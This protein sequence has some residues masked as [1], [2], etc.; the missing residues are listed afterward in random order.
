MITPLQAVILGIIE[1]IT[2][3]LP[4]SSTGHL[5]LAGEWLGI[6]GESAKAFEVIIQAGALLAVLGLYRNRIW[7]MWRGVIAK[8]AAGR[9]LLV[10]LLISF[11]PAAAAGLLFHGWIKEHL[12]HRGAVTGALA[13]GGILMI[14]VA[15]FFPPHPF[16]FAQGR[17]ALSPKK[18]GTGSLFSMTSS[19][20]FLIGLAQVLSLWPGTSRA[21]VTL[22]A[23]ILL[24][25]PVAAAAEYSFLLALPTLGAA[26]LFDFV[27]NYSVLFQQIAPLSFGIGLVTSAVVA[28][29]AIC[30]F[31]HYLTR[32]S[33]ALFGWYRIILAVLVWSFVR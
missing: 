25:F 22:V 6:Q 3:F 9:R 14:V 21:M 18:N 33:L 23:A 31:V 2:E 28:A 15:R 7:E 5:I 24:G 11:L 12:F 30:S 16:D 13:I 1:G 10:N 19:Q 8:N 27:K 17:P 26:A 4:I 32:H 20:A 29:I